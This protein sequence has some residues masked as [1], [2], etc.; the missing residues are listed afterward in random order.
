MHRE[1]IGRLRRIAQGGT[2][3]TRGLVDLLGRLERISKAFVDVSD[4]SLPTFRFRRTPKRR[5][6]AGG[7][8]KSRPRN[9][10][11]RRGR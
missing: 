6:T 5:S 2:I 4:L 1:V 11:T 9:P 8:L 3:S 7:F 10:R